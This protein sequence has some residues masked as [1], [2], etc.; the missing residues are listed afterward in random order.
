MLLNRSNDKNSGITT[1]HTHYIFQTLCQLCGYSPSGLEIAVTSGLIPH[2]KN[3]IEKEENKTL[4]AVC[5][6]L[7]SFS[8]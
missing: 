7:F 1:I 5:F 3:F 4:K 6:L 2:L 8:S